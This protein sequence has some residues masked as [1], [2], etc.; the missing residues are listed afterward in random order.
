VGTGS[1]IRTDGA[2]AATAAAGKVVA[3]TTGAVWSGM[4]LAEAQKKPASKIDLIIPVVT[5]QKK[6]PINERQFYLREVCCF[7][8]GEPENPVR[9]P[10]VRLRFT[11]IFERNHSDSSADRK[12][13]ISVDNGRPF[14]VNYIRQV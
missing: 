14:W 11:R 4:K 6:L 7:Q 8:Q 1:V 10:P 3:I 13:S 5:F 9:L 2:W 12:A